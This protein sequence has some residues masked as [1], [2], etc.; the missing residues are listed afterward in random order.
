MTSFLSTLFSNKTPEQRE[1]AARTASVETLQTNVA[2]RELDLATLRGELQS[3][4][5]MYY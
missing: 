4:K 1:L 2:Q 5:T 3:F